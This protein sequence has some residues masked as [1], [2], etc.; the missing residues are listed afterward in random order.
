MI[1]NHE[2]FMQ[3][4]Y[5]KTVENLNSVQIANKLGMS[6]R[7][8]RHWWNQTAY[9]E[10]KKITRSKKINAF[11]P[12]IESLLKDCP[13]L[14]GEQIFQKIK[15][16][17]FTGSIGCVHRLLR[18]SRPKQQRSFLSLSFDP[19]EA[20]QID[21]GDCGTLMQ[22]GKRIRLCV[23]AGVL[24]Y[25]RLLYAKIIPS[26][27]QE[28]TFAFLKEAFEFFHGVPHKLILDNF[29]AAVLHHARHCPAE[30]HPAFLD[31]CAHYGILPVACNV[32]APYEKGR[33][34]NAIGYLKGNFMR[35]NTFCSLEEAQC[36]LRNW[37]DTV[38]NVRIHSTTRRRPVDLFQET[39]QAA[40]SPVNPNVFDCSRIE[41]RHIDSQSRFCFEGSYYS[42]PS[43]YANSEVKIRITPE[44]IFAYH[45]GRQIANHLRAICKN[46]IVDDP[47][48]FKVMLEERKTASRQNM[49]AN[50]LAL[51]PDAEI[52]KKELEERVLD[53][54]RHIKR[55][56]TLV[57]IYG[58]ESV[59][60]A[61]QAAIANEVFGADYI[62]FILRMK[63]APP[64]SFQ[65]VLHVTQ[66]SDN[67]NIKLDDPDM[68]I[69]D[70]E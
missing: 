45:D 32:R 63:A 64:D 37:L 30:F 26:E 12:R 43:M 13:S 54:N 18:E 8:V 17:G 14:S 67:L 6:E 24:C 44:K 31:F 15:S 52:L 9:P 3:I 34:E 62:E 41:Q 4:R 36:S 2:K 40:L 25:S 38:A 66:G 65:S 70:V 50:F 53:S 10:E 58:K 20:M 7:L 56:L 51:G 35:G 49:M 57:D 46:S 5:L 22:N 16:T 27:K 48:H 28:Y 59:V 39:E 42:V 29:K 33:I 60:N 1:V 47:G 21:F 69:Y 19:G 23:C 61:L 11:I 68:S 55:I